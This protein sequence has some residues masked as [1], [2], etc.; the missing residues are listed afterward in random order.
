[1]HKGQFGSALFF[2]H[3]LKMTAATVVASEFITLKRQVLM[4]TAPRT[5]GCW[6]C[7]RVSASHYQGLNRLS[8]NSEKMVTYRKKKR[9]KYSSYKPSRMKQ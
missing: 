6:Y 9:T 3:S 4:G 2:L 1:M 7:S 5:D 8:E